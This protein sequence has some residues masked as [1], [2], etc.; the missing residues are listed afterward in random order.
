M[1]P[2]S[3]FCIR[4]PQDLQHRDLGKNCFRRVT[5]ETL[6][7]STLETGGAGIDL[8]YGLH[9]TPFGQILLATAASATVFRICHL[10]FVEPEAE[11]KAYQDLRVEWPQ[12]RLIA[13]AGSTQ[14]IAQQI[15]QPLLH[16]MLAPEE[17]LPTLTVLVRGTS[18]QIQVWRA[19]LTLPPG[20]LSTYG[21][22]AQQIQRPTAI[23]AVATAIGRNPIAY[24]I[25]CHRVVR[26]SG[27]LGGYRW[28][29][30][31]KAAMLA[32]EAGR[33]GQNAEDSG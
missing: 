6:P 7:S 8:H 9:P 16:P 32:W 22:I 21:A 30:D 11:A 33:D 25:P 23:R 19:L 27:E 10:R 28:G 2:V 15:F 13:D 17:S 29:V 4:Q 14:A 26:A 24:L 12:A 5:L 18:F 31:R 3:T 20:S 1:T